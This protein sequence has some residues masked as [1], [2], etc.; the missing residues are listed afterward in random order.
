MQFA[1]D[2]QSESSRPTVAALPLV[3]LPA[4][5]FCLFASVRLRGSAGPV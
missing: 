3:E 1:V 5:L 2:G 4:S